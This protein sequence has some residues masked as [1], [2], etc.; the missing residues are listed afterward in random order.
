MEEGC[1]RSGA[2]GDCDINNVSEVVMTPAYK[3]IKV[4]TSVNDRDIMSRREKVATTF[5]CRDISSTDEEVAASSRCRDI[6]NVEQWSRRQ[7]DVA[8]SHTKEAGRDMI[9]LSRQHL[10]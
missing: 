5:S 4:A 9:Q 2:Q 8:T 6:R 7:L 10:Y 1:S 3:E